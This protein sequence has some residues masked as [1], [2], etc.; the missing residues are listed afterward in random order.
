[1]FYLITVK[2]V[3][4]LLTIM[5]ALIPFNYKIAKLYYSIFGNTFV[6]Q[7]CKAFSSKEEVIVAHRTNDQG[8][9]VVGLLIAWFLIGFAN[10]FAALLWPALLVF[11]L[12]YKFI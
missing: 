11:I 1:M 6:G 2:I 10:L 12:L 8:W 4:I 5:M 9:L 3:L 7:V